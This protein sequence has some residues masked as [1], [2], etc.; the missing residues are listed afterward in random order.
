MCYFLNKR[1]IKFCQ[2]GETS[3]YSLKRKLNELFRKHV[4]LRKDYLRL[5]LKWTEEIGNEEMLILLFM[6][7]I[8]SWNPRDW[9][10]IGQSIV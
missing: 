1:R 4:Q 9:K 7:L 6:K 5:R 10:S 2:Q 8:D 3:L